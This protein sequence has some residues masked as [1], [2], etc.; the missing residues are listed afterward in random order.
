MNKYGK[1]IQ[2]QG[3][4][5]DFSIDQEIFKI[6]DLSNWINKNKEEKSKNKHLLLPYD[7]INTN[8]VNIIKLH[9]RQMLQISKH[10]K[11]IIFRSDTYNLISKYATLNKQTWKNINT[12]YMLKYTKSQK[13][14]NQIKKIECK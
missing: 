3:W 11:A 4:I 13:S 9:T 2:N 8:I 12:Q 1:L 5:Q 14:Q 7:I 6:Q 10:K